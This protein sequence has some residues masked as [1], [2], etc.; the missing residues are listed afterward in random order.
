MQPAPSV[1]GLWA[2]PAAITPL[3]MGAYQ[4]ARHAR[5]TGDEV[6]MQPEGKKEELPLWVYGGLLALGLVAAAVVLTLYFS[7][8]GPTNQDDQAKWGQLGDYVGGLLNPLFGFLGFFALLLTIW[9]QSK[10]LR[11]SRE[12]LRMSREELAK[13]ALALASQNSTLSQQNFENTFFQLLRR[14]S[15]VVADVRYGSR[16]G[17]DALRSLLVD[18]LRQIYKDLRETAD[19]AP[20]RAYEL[21]FAEQRHELGHY[22]RTLYH[23]FNFID[24]SALSEEEKSRYANIARAQL[25]AYELSLLFYNG[26]WGEGKVGFKPLVEQY[27]LLKHLDE[28]DLIDPVHRKMNFYVPTAFFSRE[29][30]KKFL[31]PVP[32][33]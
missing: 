10:E 11:L 22:F 23:I 7:S 21:F 16:S 14:F 5:E 9:F 33:S 8:F 3:G 4:I 12:E 28:R 20:V 24:L 29:Q 17:R 6:H 27:G 25:S 2:D 26:I 19:A 13:S 15:E 30:R 1:A 32:P 18:R 31:K